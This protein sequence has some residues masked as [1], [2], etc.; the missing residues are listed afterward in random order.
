[1]TDG[2][3]DNPVDELAEERARCWRAGEEP[4]VEEYVWAVSAVGGRDSRSPARRRHDGATQ[5]AAGGRAHRTGPDATPTRVPERVGE[6]RIVRE[7]GRGG[8]GVVYEAVH[9]SR[10]AASLNSRVFVRKRKFRARFRRE[11]QAAARLHHTN[12]VPVFDVGE[13]NGLWFYVM[14][15]IDGRSLDAV[16]RDAGR[17]AADTVPLTPR[18]QESGV[19]SQESETQTP[20]GAAVNSHGSPHR[21]TGCRRPSVRTRPGRV[22]PRHQAVELDSRRAR[23]RVGDR[24]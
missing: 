9:E 14:Q 13:H 6:F 5:A 24:F 15:L 12:I 18:S 1:M 10:T 8:M 19:R 17:A 21:R 16:V 3:A 11:S 20:Q 23:H 22:A 2:Q 7:I 4:S